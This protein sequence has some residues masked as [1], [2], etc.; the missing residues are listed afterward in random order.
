MNQSNIFLKKNNHFNPFESKKSFKYNKINDESKQINQDIEKTTN[1]KRNVWVFMGKSNIGKSFL[2]H[3]LEGFSVFETDCS[4][5]LPSEIIHDIVVL[6]NKYKH[7]LK[8]VKKR[9]PENVNLIVVNFN[10]Q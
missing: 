4:L 8:E 10:Q 6:G 1:Q 7:S 2:A 5:Q 3:R 9:L